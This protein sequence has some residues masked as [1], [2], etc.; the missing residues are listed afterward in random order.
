[1]PEES[2]MQR[3]LTAEFPSWYVEFDT[4]KEKWELMPLASGDWT[5]LSTS[6][7][8]AFFRS[9]LCCGVK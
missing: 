1:M 5:I 9:S 7:T 6:T 4:Q 8:G 3:T 2:D